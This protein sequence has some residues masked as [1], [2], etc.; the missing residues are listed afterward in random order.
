V[1][2]LFDIV[3]NLVQRLGAVYKSSCPQNAYYRSSTVRALVT[4]LVQNNDLIV[5]S[6]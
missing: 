2:E 5:V 1:K 3:N 6:V 4:Y